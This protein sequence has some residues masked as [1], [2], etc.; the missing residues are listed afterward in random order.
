MAG[1][2]TRL[3]VVKAD[4]T[5]EKYLHT[6]VIGTINNALTCSGKFEVY[7]AENLAEVVTHFLYRDYNNRNVST[8]EIFSIIKAVLEATRYEQAAIALSE[9]RAQRMLKRGRVEVVKVNAEGLHDAQSF[10]DARQAGAKTRWDKSVIVDDLV[11][12]HGIGQPTA[13]VIASMVE[14]K[15]FN[16]GMTSVPSSLLKQ[17]VLG[18]TAT[19]LQAERQFQN[20]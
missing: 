2:K 16:M 5:V 18:E 6:K 4:G 12:G 11:E 13:R 3:K 7:T 14:E 1:M 9:H 19:I 20:T 17:L 10:H 8:G 15:I